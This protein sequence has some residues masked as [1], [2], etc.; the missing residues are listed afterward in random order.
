LQQFLPPVQ[1][2]VRGFKQFVRCSSIGGI[3]RHANAH[4]DGRLFLFFPYMSFNALHHLLRHALVGFDQHHCK[5]VASV[6]HGQVRCAALL[7]CDLC[8]TPQRLV[9]RQMSQLVVDS[10]QVVQVQ[11]QNRNE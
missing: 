2:P 5:F 4:A 8:Q 9:S 7:F 10:F 1:L 3:Y 11:E 6:S